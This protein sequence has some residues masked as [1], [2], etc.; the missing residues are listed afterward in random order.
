MLDGRH[1]AH[2][3]SEALAVGNQPSRS[4]NGQFLFGNPASFYAFFL[5]LAVL[6]NLPWGVCGDTGT[7]PVRLVSIMNY[8]QEKEGIRKI[9]D[10]SLY[11]GESS[12][13]FPRFFGLK[14][15][16]F[17]GLAF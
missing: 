14:S 15:I 17:F 13:A 6:V 11:L 9:K 16:I 5:K 2:L 7:S 3:W 12:V 1:L 4:A 8:F 10:G